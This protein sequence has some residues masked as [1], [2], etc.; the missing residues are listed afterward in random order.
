MN[1]KKFVVLALLMIAIIALSSCML[2]ACNDDS[3][4]TND[5]PVKIEATEGLLISNGDFKVIDTAATAYPRTITSWTGAKMYSS[6]NFRDDV[7][8]GAI[9]LDKAL[10]DA[11][12]SKWADDNNEIYNKLIAGGRYGDEDEIKNALMIYMPEESTNEKGD[13][14]HGATAYGYTS[15]TFTLAKGSYY[16][17]SVDVL[18]HNI[19]GDNEFDRGAR[20]YVSS[21]TYVEFS[22]I[23][24][25]GEWKTYEMYIENT[26]AS[27]TSLTVMLGLGKYN[28]A[29]TTG[30]TTGYA[31][32]DNLT[33]EKIEDDKETDENEGETAFEQAKV[34]ELESDS[35]VKTATLKVPNGRFDFGSTTISSSGSPNNWS[36]VT[37]NRGKDDPAPTALGYNGIINTV[38]F[39]SNYSKYSSTYK[40][41][42]GE[43]APTTSY[44]PADSLVN[45]VESLQ[46]Y[47]GRVGSNVY[48]LSQQLM[49]AQGIRSSKTITI[50]KNKIYALS[51]NVYTYGIHGA[52]VSLILS[53]ADGKDI[54]IKGISSNKSSDVFIGAT[55]IDPNDNGYTSG[56]EIGEST[57]GWETFTFYIK[58]NQFNDFAYNM[59]IWLGTDGTND[60][61]SVLYHSFDSN[62]NRTTYT[63]DGTFSNGWLFVDEL[64]LTELDDVPTGSTIKVAGDDQTLD[65]AT[66]SGAYRGIFVDLTTTN[67]FGAGS[68]YILNQTTSNSTLDGVASIGAGA[69]TG[70]TSAF[71]KTDKTNPV[72]EGLIS[73]G[74]VSIEEDSFNGLG[75][76]PQLPYDIEE[77]VAYMMHASSDS[78]YEVETNPITIKANT[79]YRLSLWLKTV[80]VSSTSGAYV[81]VL[82]KDDDDATLATFSKINTNEYDEYTNDWCA[83]TIMIRGAENEDTNVSLKFTLGT[84]NRWATS[85]LTSGALYIANMNMSTVSYANFS[86]TTTGTYTKSVDLTTSYSYTFSNGAFDAYDH[87]DENLEESKPLTEQTVA[88]IPED[89]T[90]SDNTLGANTNESSLVAGVIALDKTGNLTYAP[91]T[92]TS[93]VLPNVDFNNFYPAIADAD[94]DVYPGE[95]GQ[96]LAIGSK[97]GVAYAAGYASQSISLSAN[98]FYK[99][100]V[101]VKTAGV[102]QASV[103]LTGESSSSVGDNSFLITEANQDW[104]KYTFFIS[105]GQTNV[106]LNLNLW[107]GQDVKYFDVAGATDEEKA[108]NAKSTGA[109]FFDNVFYSTIDE[110]DYNEAQAN[111]TTRVISFLTDS[112]DAISSTIESR[113]SLT[114]PKGWTGSVGTSQSSSNTKSGVI[115]ADGNFLETETVDGVDYVKILGKEYKKEDIDITDEEL[116][117]AKGSGDYEG[118]SD[119]EIIDAL[120]DAKLLKLKKDNWMPLDQLNAHS[121]S[122]ML[123]INNVEKSAYTYTSSSSTLKENSFYEVSLWMRTYNLSTDEKEGAYIELYL[124]SA[125]ESDKPFIFEAV[126]SNEWTKYT[127]LV[128][129]REEDV[130]SVTVRLSLGKYHSETVDGET[131]V[132]GTTSG[133]AMFDDVTIK[134]LDIAEEEFE[135]IEENDFLIKRTVAIDNSGNGDTDPETPNNKNEFDLENLAWMIPTIVLGLLIIIVVIVFIV[136]KVKKSQPARKAKAKKAKITSTKSIDAKHSKYDENKE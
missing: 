50:E 87:D 128:Q 56:E 117:E 94:L 136:K 116:A 63:A 118:K 32:F 27:S 78:Y 130:T 84:G 20:I 120:K 43:N 68:S 88:A 57:N 81:Y 1:K 131:V 21:N 70:W 69:P 74:V 15:T 71:D 122:R 65:C 83:L 85:T 62:G 55:K 11:N 40:T 30:L 49:T 97:D 36:L 48:M 59:N 99:L 115:F 95:N 92:Q 80:D 52:G 7:I 79:F 47:T 33:L 34:R 12:K 44:K 53:G 134:T 46:N 41:Q 3:T 111:D 103:F 18:T 123:I 5:T 13:K 22:G 100:S 133:F 28:S 58:G 37:G 121:G 67:L 75:T 106:S 31:F 76:Y 51:L 110:D 29:F 72:I 6:G 119:D 14:I 23:D 104:T 101:Y 77:K 113:T 25:H 112:F 38:N 19:G 86:D 54:V 10:Y 132:T 9:S 129:T 102:Q 93:A 2:V 45:I 89:W 8:A 127:F 61:T 105:V 39:G 135:A 107:L 82:N 108:N 66:E 4:D 96:L 109:V 73:E 42:A 125:N 91:S 64:A 90:F 24:T 60:N 16:K 124:G 114:S 35:F 26:P 98:N 17:L 126:A